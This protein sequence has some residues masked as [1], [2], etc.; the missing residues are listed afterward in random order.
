[1]KNVYYSIQYKS[2]NNTYSTVDQYLLAELAEKKAKELNK[3]SQKT[4]FVGLQIDEIANEY[5]YKGFYIIKTKKGFNGTYYKVF[6]NEDG[7]RTYKFWS[8]SLKAAKEYI[9]KMLLSGRLFDFIKGIKQYNAYSVSSLICEK[10]FN[11]GNGSLALFKL[12]PEEK[13]IKVNS[14][15]ATKRDIEKIKAFN[16]MEGLNYELFFSSYSYPEYY[17]HSF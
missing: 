17:S 15:L 16:E 3:T 1:M 8:P 10:T 13:K 11:N 4:Y 6:R 7:I 2:N 12:L 9:N 14:S 5:N